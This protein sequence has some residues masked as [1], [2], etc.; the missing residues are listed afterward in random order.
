MM[1]SKYTITLVL[2]SGLV[3]G[4]CSSGNGNGSSNGNSGSGGT[5]QDEPPPQPQVGKTLA[6]YGSQSADDD[7]MAV[8]I[9][10]EDDIQA[11]F[12]DADNVTTDVVSGDSVQAV[13]D[14]AQ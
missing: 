8:T 1:N 4:A 3:L 9:E 12:G 6:A 2:C 11:V 14:R 10:L 13:I 5:V 7:P